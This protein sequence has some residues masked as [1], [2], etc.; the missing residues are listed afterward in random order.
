M[1]CYATREKQVKIE[2]SVEE[3]CTVELAIQRSNIM[4]QFPE[5]QL[6]GIAV[7]IFGQ[8]VKLDSHLQEGDRI[9]IYRPLTLDPKE[10]RRLRAEKNKCHEQEIGRQNN[11]QQ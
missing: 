10:A 6:A 4:K 3:S 5:I 11:R 8:L 9:E 7:G 2:L 1:V